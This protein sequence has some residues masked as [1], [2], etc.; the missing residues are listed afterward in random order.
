MK[1]FLSAIL[2][3]LMTVTVFSFTAS[4]SAQDSNVVFKFNFGEKFSEIVDKKTSATCTKN[5]ESQGEKALKV[6]PNINCTDTK[7]VNLD[8]WSLNYTAKQLSEANYVTVRYK[9]TA[10]AGVKNAGKF[11]IAIAASGGALPK[12]SN[13]ESQLPTVQN[14]WAYALFDL[15]PIKD[16]ISTEEGKK[17]TQMHIKPYGGTELSQLSHDEI[18]YIS[19][20]AFLKEKPEINNPGDGTATAPTAKPDAPATQT[21]AA[22]STGAPAVDASGVVFSFNYSDKNNGIVDHHDDAAVLTKGDESQG[23]KA[24]KVVPNPEATSTKVLPLECYSLTYTPEQLEKANYVTVRYKYTAPAGVKNAQNMTIGIA[25]TGGAVSKYSSFTAVNETVQNNWAYALFDITSLKDTIVKEDGKKFQQLHINPF[26]GAQLASLSRDE[27]FYISEIAFH[28]TKPAVSNPGD[29]TATAP[30]TPAT[31]SAPAEDIPEVVFSFNYSDKNNGIVN[32]KDTATVTK[33]DESQGEKALKVVPNNDA[34][35]DKNV[36]LDCYSLAYPGTDLAKV[37]FVSVR[38]KYVAPEGVQSGESMKINL[39]TNGKALTGSVSASSPIVTNQWAEA[40]FDVSKVPIVANPDGTFKQFHLTPFEGATIGSFH[41]GEVMYISDIKFLS[42]NPDKNATYEVSFVRGNP[43]ADGVT[44]DPTRVK[45]GEEYTLPESPF[46]LRGGE[47]TGWKSSY[48]NKVYPAGTKIKAVDTAVIYTAQFVIT[49]D[50]SDDSKSL[51][52][53]SFA[54]GIVDHKDYAYVENTTFDGKDVVKL[55]LNKNYEKQSTGI[56]LDGWSYGSAGIDLAKYKYLVISYYFEGKLP[57]PAPFKANYMKGKI[58][59]KAYGNQS[60]ETI[61]SDRWA[62]AIIDL[63]NVESVFVEGLDNYNLTQMHISVYDGLSLADLTGDEVMYISQLTF[64]KE[65]PD[66]IEHHAYMKGYEGGLFKPQGNMTRA[67]ACTIV[68]RL[69]AGSDDLVPTDKTTAFTD[70]P[71]TAWYHKYVAYVE[72]LGYLKSY[73][74]A[75]LPDQAITRAEFVELVYN[76]GLLKDA[77]K[78]GVFTDVAADHPRAAVI[79]AAGKAGLVN[80]YDNGDGTFC[81]KPDNTITRAEVVKVV[82]NAYG[83]SITYEQLSRDVRYSFFD[84]PDDFWAYADICEATLDHVKTGD[85]WAYAITP[86]ASLIAGN[87]EID[88]A[89]GEAYLKEVDKLAEEKKQAILNSKTEVTVTGTSYYVDATNGN[90]DNDGKTPETAW[91]TVDRVNKATLKRGD[92]VFFKRG[93]IY[94]TRMQTKGGVTY[95]AYGEGEKPRFYG[96]PENGADA[97]KWTLME[98]TT[99]I[100]VYATEMV[101]VGAIILDGKEAALKEI[102]DLIGGEHYVRKKKDV[103][104]DIKTELNEDLEFYCAIKSKN[105]GTDKGKIYFRCDKGNP[106]TIYKDIEFNTKNNVIGVGGEDITFD[107]ICVMYGGSHGIGS[108]TTKNLTVQNCTFGW[109]GGAIQHY[110]DNGTVTRFG[111]GVEI[112]GGCDGYVIDNC[113]VYQC[114]DAGITHQY[115]NGTNNNSMYN[116]TYSNNLI[117]DCIYS[118]EYFNGDAVGGTAIRDGKN[119][120]VI[121]NILRRAGYG[122]GNQRPDGNASSHL[123]GWTSRN[124]YEKGS[125]IIENNIFDRGMWSLVQTQATYDAWCPLYDNNTFIQWIDGPI[126]FNR[127]GVKM[128]FDSLAD[129]TLKLD[130]GDKNAKVYWLPA[131]YKHQGFLSR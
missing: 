2:A 75:F 56:H 121:G 86:P 119:Y 79:A 97:S 81:F 131:S 7:T 50:L 62:Y 25:A 10:P 94:R 64:F 14:N 63:S 41:E 127:G 113:Y 20:I 70:V 37:K 85:G 129:I 103:V 71:A 17:M 48:D 91:K 23:E 44:P 111:N 104:F 58:L 40:I 6:V 21:P 124:E 65:K 73:S 52:F 38:Y 39:L 96:S 109:I 82:N 90:D 68:A 15:A 88:F 115:G 57:K 16:I 55:T 120:K 107:N 72:S 128:N 74:G 31:P 19:E 54:N 28:A 4:V 67:E 24:L 118:I 123:K 32:H 11:G 49:E 36:H 43:D 3:V 66:I 13:F 5:D 89:A 45:D 12:F 35:G 114:Y 9:Y 8:C 126:G 60:Y 29:G 33:G 61:V 34:T 110:N 95:S 26:G 42:K 93:D 27:I 130:L 76:M 46:T 84:V 117:E 30:T 106:G 100:W 78:N 122:F 101:D 99:N 47:F 125:Y 92:G 98:G 102:P 108:G 53:S 77:G 116:I 105:M 51:V 80:G 69:A 83:R 18:F 87:R 112:Y 22:P 1:K 59:T